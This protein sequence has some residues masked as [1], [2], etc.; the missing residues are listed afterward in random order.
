MQDTFFFIFNSILLG[1]G[2]AMD[3]FSVSIANGIRNASMDRREMARIA[4]VF[5][6]FQFLMPLTGWVCVHT[7][8]QIF[9]FLDDLV[10]WIALGLLV[11]IGG[12]MIREGILESQKAGGEEEAKE[13][14]PAAGKDLSWKTLLLQGIATSIDA[15]S[16]GF[17]IAHYSAGAAA[18][19]SLLIGGVTLVICLGGIRI[20]RRAGALL[21][22]RATMLGGCILIFIGLEIFVRAML[23]I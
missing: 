17:A 7:A 19:A 4:G 22:S 12:G 6:F 21:S 10:P 14:D 2:L 1:I 11:Y 8:V 5:A 13:T 15:L 23:G 3:A 16:V 9:S 18:A 20:G